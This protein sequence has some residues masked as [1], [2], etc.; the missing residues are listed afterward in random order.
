[1]MKRIKKMLALFVMLGVVVASGFMITGCKKKTTDNGGGSTNTTTKQTEKKTYAFTDVF[2]EQT[3]EGYTVRYSNVSKNESDTSNVYKAGIMG[4]V[5][6]EKVKITKISYTI[7][8]TSSSEKTV[9]YFE[10]NKNT[11]NQETKIWRIFDPDS[12]WNTNTE[13][14]AGNEE[15]NYA[16][17]YSNFVINK[18]EKFLMQF[19]AKQEVNYYNF[20][21]EFEVVE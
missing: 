6:K 15:K 7:K 4:F 18:G 2:T 11:F 14:I 21:V 9:V 13:D 12:S 20:K 19:S 10:N 3:S 8:N 1:M 17:T 16:L 5:L